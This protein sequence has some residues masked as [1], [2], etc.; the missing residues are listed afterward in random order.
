[1]GQHGAWAAYPRRGC[2]LPRGALSNRARLAADSRYRS[3]AIERRTGSYGSAAPAA[4]T[5]AA[6]LLLNKTML[7]GSGA[8]ERSLSEQPSAK[9]GQKF[10]RFRERQSAPARS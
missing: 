5:T 8:I 6:A 10:R 2:P 3:T 4:L 1:M 7:R 9:A